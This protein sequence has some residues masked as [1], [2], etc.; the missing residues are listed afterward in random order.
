MWIWIT[1]L[2]IGTF[3]IAAVSV[4]G[5]TAT[6]STKPRRS[7]YDL[8][9]A[10]EFVAESLPEDVTAQVSYEQVE[11]VLRL[12]S[13]FLTEKGLASTRT[14]DDLTE[15]LVMV[16]DDEQVAWILGRLDEQQ[17]LL[18]DTEVVRILTAEQGYYQAIGAI[19]DEVG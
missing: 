16:T 1:L 4:G 10:V 2:A 15:D 19:G 6:L 5:V 18:D 11:A 14:D 7:V 9:E 12:H 17:V 3:A 13:E 8:S